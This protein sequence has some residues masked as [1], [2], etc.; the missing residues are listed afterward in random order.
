MSADRQLRVYR[1]SRAMHATE[2]FSGE[3]ARLFGGRWNSRGVPAVYTSTSLSLAAIEYFVHLEPQFAPD[4]L[5]WIAAVLPEG[6]PASAIN[7]ADLPSDW[8]ANE[9]ATRDLGDRWAREQRSF[10][11]RVPSV[12]IPTEWNVL[13]NPLHPRRSELAIEP[14]KPFLYDARM[15][16]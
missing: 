8:R 5:V 13:I 3:G 9:S 7:P 10:A 11:L 6:E 14:P 4:D 2:A 16:R 1:I 12:P 15:F